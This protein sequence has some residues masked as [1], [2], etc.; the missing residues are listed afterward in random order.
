MI[1]ELM[2]PTSVLAVKL[3]RRRLVVVL[4]EEIYVYDIGNMKLLQS[5]E[6]Y[7]N[8]SGQSFFLFF[9]GSLWTRYPLMPLS[10]MKQ[11]HTDFMRYWIT[12]LSAHWP[13]P[14]KIATWRTLPRCRSQKCLV[15]SQACHPH[16]IHRRCQTTAMC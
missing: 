2:F 3:N 13:P 6:T 1:C 10:M 8:P 5:F 14:L 16:R 12:K 15:P 9:F 7:P 11:T 4:E